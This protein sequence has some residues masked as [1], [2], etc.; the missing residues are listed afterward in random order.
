MGENCGTYCNTID[1]ILVGKNLSLE[2][3]MTILSNCGTRTDLNAYRI[4]ALID[5]S[6]CIKFFR[7]FQEKVE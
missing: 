2:K 6:E 1:T 5:F 3:S 4:W 7:L